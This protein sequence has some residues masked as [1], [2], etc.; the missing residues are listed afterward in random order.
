MSDW[1]PSASNAT[2]RARSSIIKRIREFFYVRDILEVETPVLGTAGTV[3]VFVNSFVTQFQGYSSNLQDLYL[4]TSPEMHMKRLLCNGI[5]PIF[6]L[7]KAFRN[8]EYGRKHNPEFTMLEWYIPG[9]NLQG[10]MQQTDDFLQEVL[11]APKS[12][13][14]SYRDLFLEHMGLCPHLSN[15]EL[16]KEKVVGLN[17]MLEMD[18]ISSKDTLL[19]I[20]FSHVIEP[21]LP[22]DTPV[23]VYDFTLEQAEL[24]KQQE[25]SIENQT[26][27]VAKR[28]E[29]YYKGHELANGYW[30]LVDAREQLARF[31]KNVRDRA[32]LGLPEVPYDKK[33]I[34]AL[35][36][37]MP[38]CAGI[39]VGVDRIIMLALGLSSIDQ[40]M[41]FSFTRT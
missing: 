6:Q 20:L 32:K 7:S 22:S 10:L 38:E 26:V 18:N 19:E 29:V 5:G 16:L 34:E 1:Q 24:A 33:L 40:A 11:N 21:L 12:L 37:G 27:K 41:A 9:M 17:L 39:A 14:I 15:V 28:F 2:L 31:N 36:S 3:S 35:A 23:F 30:E 13:R 8:S 25:C 4:Q